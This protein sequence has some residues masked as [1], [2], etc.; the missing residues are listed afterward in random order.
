MR[1]LGSAVRSKPL[2][3]AVLALIS[4]AAAGGGTA[5]ADD[6]AGSEILAKVRK[7]TG[8]QG[9]KAFVIE[10]QA[11]SYGSKGRF[12]VQTGPDG[13]F[14]KQVDAPLGFARGDDGTSGWEVDSTGMPRHLEADERDRSRLKIWIWTGQWLDPN[15]KIVATPKSGQREGDDVV[16][17]VGM[18]GS[19]GRG[20]LSIDRRSWLPRLLTRRGPAGT[21]VVAFS[22]YLEHEGR[23][24]AGSVT[25]KTEG[26]STFAGSVSAIGPAPGRA[27][28]RF[29]APDRQ[30]DDTRFDAGVPAKVRLERARTGHLLVYPSINGVEQGAFVF[31]SGAAGTVIAPDAAAVL[32]LP[33]L[34][35]VPLPSIFGTTAAKIHRS[36]TFT[37][38]P[39]TISG[40]FLVEMDLAPL[41][42]AFGRSVHGIVGYDLFRRCV[43]DLT[44]ADDTLVLREGNAGGLENL[45]WGP[46]FLPMRHPAVGARAAGVPEG[47]YRLD[48]GA[49]GA[50]AGN[51]TFHGSTV[52]EFHLLDGRQVARAAAGKLQLGIGQIDW[53]ELAGHRFDHPRVLFALETEGVLGRVGT[54]GN[55]GT[56]FLRPFRVCFDYAHA[57]IAFTELTA[58]P[59]SQSSKTRQLRG[60]TPEKKVVPRRPR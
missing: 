7:A 57:R 31:D 2:G 29:A 60:K 56:E 39:V 45:A 58:A 48:L 16:L 13:A 51:V 33:E 52:K 11:E 17:E 1:K 55:I 27:A 15:A 24:V 38:G 50:P 23:K 18:A 37:L 42:A 30:P 19:V 28:N 43:I 21:E 14:R 41:N 26:I 25:S 59:G 40:L 20:E 53:F 32:R 44:L 34:G 5:R 49:A 3:R 35:L 46:L 47:L 4:A 54:L 10:G 6:G 12:T 8:W 9:S 36:E 22:R